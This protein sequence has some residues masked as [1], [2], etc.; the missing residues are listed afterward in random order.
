MIDSPGACHKMRSKLRQL[1]FGGEARRALAIAESLTAS[2]DQGLNVELVKAEIYA[3]GGIELGRA[4]L[5]ETSVQIWL[6]V[7]ENHW[8]PN[9]TYNVAKAQLELWRLAVKSVGMA[10]AWLAKRKH[11]HEARRLYEQVARDENAPTELRMTALTALANSYDIVG[12]YLDAIDCY[13]RALK[14]DPSFGIARGHRAIALLDASMLIGAHKG[15]LVRQAAADLVAAV[16]DKE[17]VLEYGGQEALD[18]FEARRDTITIQ[19]VNAQ[20]PTTYR[21]ALGEPYLDWCL[22]KRLF[23]HNWHDCIHSETELLDPVLC[24]NISFTEKDIELE[25]V[26]ELLDAF[27]A[28]KR[29]YTFARY[30]LWLAVAPESPIAQQVREINRRSSY[31]DTWTYANWNLRTGFAIGAMKAAVDVLDKIAVFLHLYLGSNLGQ[32][33]YFHNLPYKDKSREKLSPALSKALQHPEQNKS[34]LALFDLSSEVR[35]QSDTF[36]GR[37]VKY[38]TCRNSSLLRGSHGGSR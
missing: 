24:K 20:G 33:L 11:L 6:A 5:I 4:D 15:D 25:D 18:V 37:Q 23:L 7:L 22:N 9:V 10:S 32:N 26:N 2:F 1:I 35:D 21:R 19:T 8:S 14:I 34:L 17:R 12:R 38:R 29:D 30:E 27:N 3:Q 28:I 31:L 13:G 36:L 16:E